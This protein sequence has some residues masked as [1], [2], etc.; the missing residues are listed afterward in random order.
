[1]IA[2]RANLDNWGPNPNKK[3]LEAYQRQQ[4]LKGYERAFKEYTEA[5][6]LFPY[7]DWRYFIYPSKALPDAK[8]PFFFK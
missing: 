1:M 8:F 5:Y 4:A 7:V 6:D 2:A 3:T